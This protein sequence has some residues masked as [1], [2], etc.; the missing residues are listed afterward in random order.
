MFRPSEIYYFRNAGGSRA[1]EMMD[2]YYFRNGAA[3]Q[4]GE[5]QMLYYLQIPAE[6]NSCGARKAGRLEIL[7]GGAKRVGAMSL[8]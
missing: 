2:H 4:D 3:M 7:P 6:E 1:E 8:E 5:N